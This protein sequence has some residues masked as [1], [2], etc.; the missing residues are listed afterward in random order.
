MDFRKRTLKSKNKVCWSVRS[1]LISY[2]LWFAWESDVFSSK[3]DR[4]SILYTR[5]SI[6]KTGSH[7][8]ID[9]RQNIRSRLEKRVPTSSP[10]VRFGSI[11]MAPWCRGSGIIA[12]CF[13]VLFLGQWLG[14]PP[15]VLDCLGSET[16]TVSCDGVWLGWLHSL[17]KPLS[18][19]LSG[20][21]NPHAVTEVQHVNDWLTVDLLAQVQRKLLLD[22]LRPV[23]YLRD[24]RWLHSSVVIWASLLGTSTASVLLPQVRILI[25]SFKV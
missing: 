8:G 15:F 24:K 5:V 12:F 13:S 21:R 10:Q 4:P 25:C 11:A 20:D 14:A 16:P 7:L 3:L 17:C 19:S 23:V 2:L 22:Q 9:L 6:G 1:S 18:S